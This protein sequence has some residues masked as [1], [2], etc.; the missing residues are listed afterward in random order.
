MYMCS[1]GFGDD[2]DDDANY[3]KSIQMNEKKNSMVKKQYRDWSEFFGRQPHTNTQW[4]KK[5]W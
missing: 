5:K 3:S 1:G 2:D 4:M